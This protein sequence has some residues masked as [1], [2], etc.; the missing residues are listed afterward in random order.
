MEGAPSRHTPDVVSWQHPFVAIDDVEAQVG[1]VT[2]GQPRH[3]DAAAAV[4]TSGVELRRARKPI[5]VGI[6]EALVA[7][8]P[9]APQ[10]V[11]M[12]RS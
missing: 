3:R 8:A 4:V 9:R 5:E 6:E 1:V 10:I 12:K 11:S 7:S 2:C